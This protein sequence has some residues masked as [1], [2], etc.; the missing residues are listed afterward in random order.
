[1][2]AIDRQILALLQK[3]GRMTNAALAE[4]VHL[5]PSPCL[6]RVKALEDAGVIAGYR[7]VLDREHV[8]LG[9]TVFIE[10]KVENP[11]LE[12]V[13]SSLQTAFREMDEVVSCHIVSGLADMLIEVVVA[14]LR[15]YEQLLMGRLL[16]LEGVADVKSNFVIRTVKATGPLPVT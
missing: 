5:S 16:P 10:I 2:D 1:M 6:R 14:D 3:D 9:L 4:A 11:H 8:G 13:T 15:H 12:T 7:A